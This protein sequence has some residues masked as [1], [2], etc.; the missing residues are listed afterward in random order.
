MTKSYLLCLMIANTI[1]ITMIKTMADATEIPI[2]APVL[3]ESGDVSFET[4]SFGT[5]KQVQNFYNNSTFTFT[6]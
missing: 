4:V 3:S 6:I 5:G 1:A 2:I